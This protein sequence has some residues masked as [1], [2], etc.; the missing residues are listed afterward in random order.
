VCNLMLLIF[1]ISRV[2]LMTQRLNYV[3]FRQC[4]KIAGH[5]HR[6]TD[7]QFQTNDM[8]HQLRQNSYTANKHLTT[9][10]LLDAYVQ[11]NC[12]T[13]WESNILLGET[14][15]AEWTGLLHCINVIRMQRQLAVVCSDPA[16]APFT[17]ATMSQKHV[18][19]YKSNNFFDKV[20]CCFD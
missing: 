8:S 14:L 12:N 16:K 19:C 11:A 7:T 17:P 2:V 13:Y 9:M 5:T 18:E 4:A 10:R 3:I 20:Q 6:H 1:Y 15:Y